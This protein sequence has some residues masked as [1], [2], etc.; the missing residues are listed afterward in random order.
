MDMDAVELKRDTDEHRV[1][2]MA[3]VEEFAYSLERRGFKHDADK[4][5]AR[6]NINPEFHDMAKK[7]FCDCAWWQTHK[8][9][10]HHDPKNLIDLLEKVIDGVSACARRTGLSC[11]QPQDFSKFNLPGMLRDFEDRVIKSMEKRL[12]DELDT[13]IEYS[14]SQIAMA[15][16]NMDSHKW[17]SHPK[18][19]E[20]IEEHHKKFLR[21]VIRKSADV[22]FNNSLE[23]YLEELKKKERRGSL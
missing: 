11:Y 5:D 12:M 16:K 13:R 4:L 20:D 14:K 7:G 3:L 18:K 22:D 2:V 6:G 9:E 1:D 8:K 17:L 15:L 23:E 21:G 10:G 19:L